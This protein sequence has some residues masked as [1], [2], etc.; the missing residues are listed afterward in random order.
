M[1]I[2]ER[3]IP[4]TILFYE[5]PKPKVRAFLMKGSTVRM[6]EYKEVFAALSCVT[7][8]IPLLNSASVIIPQFLWHR[9]EEQILCLEFLVLGSLTMTSPFK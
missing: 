6:G 3:D 7:N 8:F 4:E 2:V 5:L 1:Q 9:G